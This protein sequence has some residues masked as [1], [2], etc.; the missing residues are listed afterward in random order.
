MSLHQ[1]VFVCSALLLAPVAVI[2]VIMRRQVHEAK[3]GAGS[4]EIS[5]WD[6]R[7]VN[8]MFGK[9]GIWNAHKNAYEHSTLR[10]SFVLLAVAWLVSVMVAVVAFWVEA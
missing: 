9:Y 5:P 1:V 8:G 6:A 4:S 2:Q 10:V 3:Y 7:F